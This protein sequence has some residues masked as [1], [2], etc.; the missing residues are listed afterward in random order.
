MIWGTA[1]VAWICTVF[2][3]EA[4]Y[5]REWVSFHVAAGFEHFVLYDNDSSDDWRQQLG[6]AIERGIVEVRD[7]PGHGRQ[8]AAYNDA[9][10]RK[11]ECDWLAFIDCDEFLFAVNGGDL[12]RSL[13][14]YRESPGVV[15]HWRQFGTNGHESYGPGFVIERFTKS[16]GCSNPHTKPIVRPWLVREF[17]SPHYACF[18]KG[19][20]AV[21]ERNELVPYRGTLENHSDNLLRVNHYQTKSV[22]EFRKKCDRGVAC[23]PLDHS[24]KFVDFD[25]AVK[26]IGQYGRTED[27]GALVFL[28]ATRRIYRDVFGEDPPC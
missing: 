17:F 27:R 28:D 9:I 26:R 13:L 19:A 14:R 25:Y 24:E 21:N 18:L 10:R 4:P 2:K 11:P 16:V 20:K 22:E 8:V 5:L 23:L 6:P 7:W 12:S 15:V 1:M 3:E